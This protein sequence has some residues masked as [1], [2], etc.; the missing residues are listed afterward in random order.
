MKFAIL[1][2]SFV[3]AINMQAQ[4]KPTADLL[5]TNAK[6]WTGDKAHP[7]AQAV[8]VLADRIVAV[9]SNADVEVL[10]GRATKTIDARGKLLLPGFNDAHVHFVDGGSQLDSVQLNDA[11]STGEFVRRIAEQAKKTAT[12]EW[13]QGGDWDETKWSPP[14]LPTKELIDPVTPNNPVFLSR[15][16]GHS[17]LA[18]STGLRLAGI[19]SQTSDPPGGEIVRDAQ[20]NPTGDL[21]DAA[22]DLVFKVIPPRTHEQRLRA[23][24]RALEYAASLGVTS[25]QNMNPDCADIAAYAELLQNGELTTRIYAAPLIDQVDD[26]VKIGIRHAFGG[27]YLRIGAVK[28]FADGS[29]GSRTAYFFEPYSDEPGNRGLLGEGMQ[30]LSLMR[31]RM[32]KADAAGLQ[33]CTHAIGDQAIS[34][35]LDLYTDVVKAHGAIER[36]FRIEHAQHMATKDFDRFSQLNVIASVQP[37]QAIDDGR[38]AEAYI[39]HDRA[40]RTYAFRTFLGHGVHLAFGTDWDVAPLNPLLTV[41]AAVTRATLDGK[42]P[43]GWFP[44]QKLTVAE[45][46]EAYTTGSAYAEF[47]EKEKGSITPGKLADMVLLSDDIFTIDPVKIRDVK[48]LKTIVGGRLVWD[49]DRGSKYSAAN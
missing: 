1:F 10:H 45:A 16:D 13:I 18:N 36:R 23:V 26:Q 11:S 12:G 33:I 38:W 47:Q 42:N 3:F 5:I 49:V 37:Y 14:N 21:K 7:T 24:R 8:A 19:T 35:V 28:A 2:L 43:N 17:A 20:G 4:S 29:L 32:I 41:Y 46:V 48:V 22:M 39:G 25:V 40:S 6:V 27:P 15:Y 30:T 31:D 34:T 9:G 44:E